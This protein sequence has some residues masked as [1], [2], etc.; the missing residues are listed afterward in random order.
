[1]YPIKQLNIISILQTMDNVQETPNKRLELKCNGNAA[2][3]DV[4]QWLTNF[5]LDRAK[6]SS[7]V[8]LTGQDKPRGTNF[9]N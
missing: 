9:G 4:Q 6:S 1:M 8:G 2:L 5:S 7:P 3:N